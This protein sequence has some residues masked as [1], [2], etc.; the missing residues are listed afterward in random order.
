MGKRPNGGGESQG[1]C[2][3]KC[4]EHGHELSQ[5][6]TEA[7]QKLYLFPL[8]T[9]DVFEKTGSCS[10]GSNC[11]FMHLSAS[12]IQQQK[13]FSNAP[14]PQSQS[15]PD[16]KQAEENKNAQRPDVQEPVIHQPKHQYQCQFFTQGKC[17]R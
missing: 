15:Q 4:D 6:L 9:C 13:S 17:I 5:K 1:R 3:F 8:K 10:F 11:K 12:E 7:K 2:E 16:L 14:N